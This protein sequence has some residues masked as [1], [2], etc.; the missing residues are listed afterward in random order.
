MASSQSSS[1][2]SIGLNA[3][4]SAPLCHCSQP[5]SISIS[6][7]DANPGRRF[8]ECEEHGFFEWLDKDMPCLWPKKSLLEAREKIRRQTEEIK[9]LREALCRAN[10]QVAK[11]HLTRSTAPNVD[12][13]KSIEDIVKAQTIHF[14]QKF[15]QFV[16]YSWG[17]FVVATTV[18]AYMLKG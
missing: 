16:V 7:T 17:G 18:I 15:L 14:D 11:V 1:S 10:A 3:T 6:W 12:I 4:N 9:A 2:A 5:T 13:L 8:F